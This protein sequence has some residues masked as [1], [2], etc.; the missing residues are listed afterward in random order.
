MKHD[1]LKDMKTRHE[2]TGQA[3]ND[4]EAEMEEIKE[5]PY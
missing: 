3:P 4:D 5:V 1:K 2:S